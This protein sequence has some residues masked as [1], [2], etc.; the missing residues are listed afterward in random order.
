MSKAVSKC[1][2]GDVSDSSATKCGGIRS[3]G[4]GRLSSTLIRRKEAVEQFHRG[5]EASQPIPN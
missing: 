1:Q 4:F 3:G 5:V 2:A